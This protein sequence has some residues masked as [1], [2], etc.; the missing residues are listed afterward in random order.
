M[1]KRNTVAISLMLVVMLTANAQDT[2]NESEASNTEF[3]KNVLHGSIS[4]FIIINSINVNYDRLL[5]TNN[6]GFF[7]AYY[8]TARAGLFTFLNFAPGGD[9]VYFPLSLGVTGLS[10]SKKDHFELSLGLSYFI[11]KSEAGEDDPIIDEDFDDDDSFFIPNIAIGY[12]KQISKGGVFRA[13][14]GWP[15]SLYVGWGYSF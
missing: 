15:E 4:P 3:S 11:D 2:S 8:G 9:S 10:G 6:N 14:L 5:A 1:Y 13:G 7:K 12:R